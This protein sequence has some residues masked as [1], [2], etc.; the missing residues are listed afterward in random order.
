MTCREFWAARP[1]LDADVR[2]LEHT[3]ECAPCAVRL[4][5]QRALGLGL[6]RVARQGMELQAPAALEQRVVEA[7]R[8]HAQTPPEAR[9]TRRERLR[10]PVPVAA[11][12]LLV[13][14]LVGWRHLPRPLPP[15][16]NAVTAASA[17]LDADFIPLPYAGEAASTD[18]AHLIRVEMPR[19]ALVTLG[20]PVAE[21]DTE[22]FVEAEV[23][24]GMGGAPEAVRILQ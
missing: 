19:S 12:M 22:E 6:R 13:A 3:R 20:V 18:D 7:F 8:L 21:D 14:M 11:A 2:L 10:W 5:Q 16:P 17:D 4:E 23:L 24:L 9:R 15:V 1:E